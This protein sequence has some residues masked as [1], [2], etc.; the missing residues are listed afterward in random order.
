MVKVHLLP[1]ASVQIG[2][3]MAERLVGVGRI[4]L[5]TPAMSTRCTSPHPAVS[6]DTRWNAGRIWSRLF[7]VCAQGRF[8]VNFG[9]LCMRGGC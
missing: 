8:K 1:R 7:S 3:K 6:R 4:E 2:P 5:P 9:R